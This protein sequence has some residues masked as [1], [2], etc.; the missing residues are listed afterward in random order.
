[1][2]RNLVV[3][4]EWN[5][6]LQILL[7]QPVSLSQ[8]VIEVRC[9]LESLLKKIPSKIFLFQFWYFSKFIAVSEE[10]QDVKPDVAQLNIKVKSADG[11]EGAIRIDSIVRIL[12]V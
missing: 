3:S 7:P 11:N 5:A 12:I 9:E 1:M 8:Y 6:R 2:A 10:A 4:D